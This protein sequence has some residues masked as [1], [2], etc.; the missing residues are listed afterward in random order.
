MNAT[1]TRIGRRLTERGVP[2]FLVAFFSSL[3]AADAF[4]QDPDP[5][6]VKPNVLLVVDTSGS[7]E[8]KTDFSD[9]ADRYPACDP[10]NPAGVNEK[11]RW[12]E[13]I[14][15]LTGSIDAADYSCE[16][17]NRSSAAFEDEFG[18][19]NGGGP[20]PDY[21]FRNPYHRPISDGCVWSPDTATSLS[22][23]FEWVPPVAMNYPVNLTSLPSC[24]SAPCCD[25]TQTGGFID[26]F[27][28]LVRFGL[29]TFDPLPDEGQG[30]TGT[31][32]PVYSEGLEG[33][34]SYYDEATSNDIDSDGQAY[35]RGRPVGCPDLQTL[36]V[37]VRNAAAPASEGKMIYFGDPDSD[38]VTDAGRHDRIKKVLLS[39]RPFGATPINGALADVR[40]FFW[41]DDDFDPLEPTPHVAGDL[42]VS[43]R[44]DDR[45]ECGCR[46][47]HVILITDGEPNFD[48]RPGCEEASPGLTSGRCPFSDDPEK[49]LE[50]LYDQ[51]VF[52]KEDPA[53]AQSCVV[54]SQGDNQ[55]RIPTHV[56]GFAT[57]TFE[58]PSGTEDCAN[59]P[60]YDP[61]WDAT[62]GVCNTE[63]VASDLKICCTLHEL[64]DAGSGGTE[65]PHIAPSAKDLKSQ[66]SDIISDI[67]KASASATRPVRSPGVGRAEDLSHQVAFRILTS[68][69]TDTGESGLWRGNIERMRWTCGD[70][71]VPTEQEKDESAGDDF[72][73]NV[74]SNR[75]QREFSTAYL[76]SPNYDASG[77][78]RPNLSGD[79]GDGAGGD[80]AI[81]EPAAKGLSFVA[82]VDP[83]AMGLTAASYAGE[84]ACTLDS[85]TSDEGK[86][87]ERVLNWTLGFD[88]DHGRNRCASM[89]KEE[90]CSLIGHVMHS[91][92]VIVDRPKAAVE[93]ASYEAFAKEYQ[94]RMMMMYVSSNDG[95]LHG[96]AVSPNS[97]SDPSI[98]STSYNNE[99][100]AFIPPFVLPQLKDQYP[101]QPGKLLDSTAVVQDVVA[102]TPGVTS[103]YNYKLERSLADAEAS[104]GNTWRTILVQ[105]FGGQQSGYFALDI[106]DPRKRSIN[107]SAGPR[108][109]WQ[110]SEVNSQPLFGHGGTPLI[111]TIQMI[112]SGELKEVAVAVLP[113]GFGGSSTGTKLRRDPKLA[114]GDA[115]N[116]YF[117]PGTS[118]G[119]GADNG[120]PRPRITDYS[121][122]DEAANSLTIV[123]LDNGTILRTFRYIAPTGLSS[124]VLGTNVTYLDSPITGIPAAFPSGTGM[125]ADRIFV[126]DQDG[127]LWRVDVSSTDPDDWTMKMFYDSHNDEGASD[128]KPITIAPVLSVNQT[129][130]ITVA[131]AT[132]AQDL[133]G[134][135]S[136]KQFIYSLT[137][138]EDESRTYEPF[139]AQVNWW[140]EL[141]TGEHILGPM[142]LTNETLYFSTLAP[143][144]SNVCLPYPS[145]IW[146]V[147][148][149]TPLDTSDLSLGGA[150]AFPVGTGLQQFAPAQD[151]VDGTGVVGPVFGVSVEYT[152][153]CG[154]AADTRESVD[155]L[156]GTRSNVQNASASNLQ[157]VF[158]TGTTKTSKQG[159]NFTTGF[160]AVSLPQPR[161][162]STLLSWAA[163]LD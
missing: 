17:I 84:G 124:S 42:R 26:A 63:P 50:T 137:E 78:L 73:I 20:P 41:G 46:E 112:D 29:M 67:A 80:V 39:T 123:R 163:I 162:P 76:A 147:H 158:Q 111:T 59:L 14:E 4:A 53:S 159:L 6:G 51:S 54:P 97:S 132:G 44:F 98:N 86:C 9:F 21:E 92:P 35:A 47:Q 74:T 114:I 2:G 127:A 151:L 37:G 103:R 83:E 113:G 119:P 153:S 101:D 5:A 110:L 13:V 18:M 45:V 11:S 52:N 82:A 148:Y 116:T 128:G 75:S 139:Y 135:S 43:P 65:P 23:A 27:G 8:Y 32:G 140:H 58:T 152:P 155:Y 133:S 33:T 3:F 121:S 89:S 144:S 69:E 143:S 141:D 91:S 93:D 19:P 12:I 134:G 24:I 106:T 88:D 81:S 95:I 49:I 105:G 109:L 30:Y 15:V 48:L 28:D 62:D 122:S 77:N 56:I 61:N 16:S 107:S 118:G 131:Y 146:G 142:S 90:D 22:N 60:T 117:K 36:E 156:G 66:L 72:A 160:E 79:P 108:L 125:I 10:G 31:Y 94:G 25:F 99:H 1:K 87:A 161:V 40:H 136:D 149:L 102:T 85:V 115:E 100:F 55:W 34:W 57:S 104:G 120:L 129:G 145:N 7:M 96:F 68:Y 70:T 157:L 126:G 138:A 64:A 38:E 71:S 130:H 154:K 150:A